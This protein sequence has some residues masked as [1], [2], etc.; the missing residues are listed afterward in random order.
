MVRYR[1][2]GFM[3]ILVSERRH[4]NS[5]DELRRL[6]QIIVD[7][8]YGAQSAGA[9]RP[10]LDRR[11]RQMPRARLPVTGLP[12]QCEFFPVAFC[13][14]AGDPTTRFTTRRSARP[15]PRH[16]HHV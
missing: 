12:T 9:P 4:G 5:V 1:K 13:C 14:R 11:H 3:A 6:G 10:Q 16:Q 15:V 2:T 8:G 7:A